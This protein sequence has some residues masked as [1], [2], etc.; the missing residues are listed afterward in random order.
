MYLRGTLDHLFFGLARRINRDSPAWGRLMCGNS[1]RGHR[2]SQR[3]DCVLWRPLRLTSF[4][5]HFSDLCIIRLGECLSL[6]L[7]N[8]TRA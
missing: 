6:E 8:S 5:K 1:Y 4:M 2:G 3:I 7:V